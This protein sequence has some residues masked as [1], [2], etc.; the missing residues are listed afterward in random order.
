MKMNCIIKYCF[1]FLIVLI[2]SSILACKKTSGSD[3][4]G[5]GTTNPPPPPPPPPAVTVPTLSEVRVMLVDKNATEETAALF[6]NLKKVSKTNILFGH[7][8]DTKRGVTNATTQWENAQQFTGVPRDKSDVKEVSGSYPMV[9]GH[10]FIHIANFT[11]GP[12]YDYEK[13]IA[14]DLTVDA[15]NRGGV[16][17]YAW[18]YANP[19]SKGSFYWDESPVEAVSKI[20]PGGSNHDVY[21]NSLKEIADFAKSLIGADGKFVPVIF[22]P[23]HEFDGG[24]FW[25]GAAH[26]SASDFKALYQFTVTYLRDELGVRNFLYAWSPDKNFTSE[27]NYLER[28]PGDAYVDVVGTDNY[29]DLNN[30]FSIAA[31]NK[32][33]IVSD[34]AK[35]KNKIAAMTETGTTDNFAK[36]D[37]FTNTLLKTLTNQKVELAY[38]LVWANTKNSFYTPY[39]GHAAEADFINFKND[40]YVYFASEAPGMYQIK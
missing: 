34:Y 14:H 26:C 36:T 25:W 2:N 33:K 3:S 31:S 1:V 10:D 22:R 19:V 38:V 13:Q 7:Q 15:Y 35:V 21:K 23:F 28:Y 6:Y 17:T 30:G 8:D 29:W 20:L 27:T 4:D 18:H 5:T 32:L 16:N 24:W 40:A 12:W 37:W 9:Y 39:K 11:D